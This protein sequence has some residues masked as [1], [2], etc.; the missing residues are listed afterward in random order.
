MIS[1]RSARSKSRRNAPPDGPDFRL[2][3][4]LSAPAHAPRRPS[5]HVACFAYADQTAYAYGSGGRGSSLS[6]EAMRRWGFGKQTA[7]RSGGRRGLAWLAVQCDRRRRGG[8][9]RSGVRPG[10]VT[11]RA[12]RPTFL[13]RAGLPVLGKG[14]PPDPPA[15]KDNLRFST[16]RKRNPSLSLLAQC[17]P[18]HARDARR[19]PGTGPAS[20]LSAWRRYAHPPARSPVLAV[21]SPGMRSPRDATPQGG[22]RRAAPVIP[23]T[24]FGRILGNEA[25]ARR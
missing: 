12:S 15:R 11:E 5:R 16:S 24:L 6:P 22:A 19:S 2:P 17:D 20:S 9:R 4:S 10:L 1:G 7:F 25:P 23:C 8:E 14:I 13:S 3:F 21:R 18:A